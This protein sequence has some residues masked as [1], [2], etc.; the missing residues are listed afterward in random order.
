VHQRSQQPKALDQQ[1]S[2]VGPAPGQAT[3]HPL[4]MLQRSVG[5]QAVVRFLSSGVRAS[6]RTGDVKDGAARR[7]K[8]DTGR[9]SASDEVIARYFDNWPAITP[10]EQQR[11]ARFDAFVDRA[12]TAGIDRHLVEGAGSATLAHYGGWTYHLP[13][14]FN[15]AWINGPRGF[16]TRLNDLLQAKVQADPLKALLDAIFADKAD[17]AVLRALGRDAGFQPAD[18]QQQP[19]PQQR[20]QFPSGWEARFADACAGI[21]EANA[22]GHGEVFRA[23]WKHATDP[24]KRRILDI[25][26]GPRVL[27]VQTLR[28]TG[29]LSDMT[30]L[31]EG[32]TGIRVTNT[33]ILTGW[34]RKPTGSLFDYVGAFLGGGYRT[35]YMSKQEREAYR[36]TV[37]RGRVTLPTKQPL[38]GDNIYVLAANW[39]FYGGAKESGLGGQLT[40]EAIHHS[41]FMAGEPVHGAGHLVTDNSGNLETVDDQSGHYRVGDYELGLVLY[42]LEYDR[43]DLSN[44]R[45][46][47]R[48]LNRPERADVFLANWKQMYLPQGQ[49]KE[50]RDTGQRTVTTAEQKATVNM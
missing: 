32:V 37:D 23:A 46:G 5:N 27:G 7:A 6:G 17:D 16:R 28:P 30:Y 45:I 24:Q 21:F 3:V 29:H 12:V 8:V 44:V 1:R 39:R 4:Q 20:L 11:K 38:K 13:M 33:A 48:I 50:P 47:P 36:L 18:Q 2:V 43:T 49:A 41:S 14:D 31:I 34:A 26:F 25:V 15:W 22:A 10:E 40:S 35:K 19:P 9:L 42:R